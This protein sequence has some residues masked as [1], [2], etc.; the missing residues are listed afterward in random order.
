[1]Q[2]R[3]HILLIILIGVSLL[4]TVPTHA[5]TAAG[6][7]VLFAETGHTLGYSFRRFFEQHG[8]VAILGMPITE[9]FLDEGRP[10]QYFE[11][12]RLEW[13]ATGATVLAGH[14]GRWAAQDRMTEPPFTPLTAESVP[15][16]THFF[17]ETGHTLQGVFLQ[18]W[19]E[20]GG[21]V[22]FGY[23][24]SEQF[25]EENPQDGQTY[26]VQYFER[27]R[28][29]WHPELPPESRV[30]LGHLG[31]QYLAANPVPEWAMQPAGSA[32]Q[33][34]DG[35]RPHH[36]RV[37]RIGIDSDIS[38]TGFSFNEWEVPRHTIA[39]YWPVSAFPNTIGN[40]VL[41]GHVGY[42][43][44]LFHYLPNIREG[45]EIFLAVGGAERR[46]TVD[47]VMTLLPDDTWVMQPTPQETLTLITCIPIGV[48]SHRLIV[49]AS[50]AT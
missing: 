5:D 15:D 6:E 35:I 10:V 32:S 41:A 42:T 4:S 12:A 46:Y 2:K 34:W 23:P 8:G 28:F 49:R 19:Q 44:I 36:I 30:Q 25:A 21:V 26:T 11:R 48:Y 17:A 9:V 7:P 27:A 22:T 14:L 1:M 39:H 16:G 29:E 33:A 45:D 43:G 40:I 3:L 13:H 38:M 24:L 50:P 47:A 18:F 31:R 20:N 37:P